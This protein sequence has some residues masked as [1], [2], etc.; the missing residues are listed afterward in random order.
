MRQV[1]S[2]SSESVSA[3]HIALKREPPE[4]EIC[5]DPPAVD[6]W[7]KEQQRTLADL[8]SWNSFDAA[9]CTGL[10]PGLDHIDQALE[11]R[12]LDDFVNAE[13]R[14]SPDPV[15]RQLPLIDR[16]RNDDRVHLMDELSII[17]HHIR[18][19]KQRH[20]HHGAH[21]R[22]QKQLDLHG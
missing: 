7:T 12:T 11:D 5:D 14:R 19:R 9:A 16:G 20:R 10:G 15:L 13:R 6:P 22:G 21:K 8:E 17:R 18:R 1:I 3:C 2:H 4:R